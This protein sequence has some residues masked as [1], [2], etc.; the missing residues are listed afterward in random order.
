[1]TFGNVITPVRTQV[2]GT[3]GDNITLSCSYSSAVSLQWYRQYH[4]S[5]PEYLLIILQGTGKVSR[6]SEIVDLDPRI[7]GKLNEEKTRVYLEISSAKVT[8]SAMYYCAMQPTVTGNTNYTVQK[9]A[10]PI[11]IISH[12]LIYNLR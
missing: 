10:R 6:K 3:E 4:G 1:V 12:A 11:E 8:D 5:A 2:S 9:L 7:S